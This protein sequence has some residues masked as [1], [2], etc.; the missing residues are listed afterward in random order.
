M[1]KQG[2]T[3][4]VA[5]RPIEVGGGCT[6]GHVGHHRRNNEAHWDGIE[7]HLNAGPNV[8]DLT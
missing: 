7:G 5:K 6:L 3:V 2:L 4:R 1:L 8:Q